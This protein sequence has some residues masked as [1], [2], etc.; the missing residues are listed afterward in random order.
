MINTI[1]FDLD[2]TLLQINNKDF[3][4]LY[5]TSMADLFTDLYTPQELITLIWS[6]TKEMILDV[7]DS[8]NE[9]SFYNSLLKRIS[10]EQLKRLQPRFDAFYQGPFDKLR[11]AVVDNTSMKKAVH[12]LKDKGYRLIIATNPLFPK[13]AIEKRI[14]WTGIDRNIFDYVS[15]FEN[16]HYCKPQVQFYQEILSEIKAQAETCLMVGNDSL[17]DMVAKHAGMQTYLVVDQLIQSE[18][19]ID[20]DHKGTMEDFLAF[21]QSLP[22]LQTQ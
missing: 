11:S 18:K 20:P 16:N 10:D 12:V 3:E 19:A 8:T 2:G 4:E 17:E 14:R 15:S 22:P 6:C 21:A 13:R 5:F 9:E 7:S 1:L